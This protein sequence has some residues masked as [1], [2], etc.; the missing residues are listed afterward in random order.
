MR[1]HASVLQW[2]PLVQISAVFR[3]IWYDPSI[4]NRQTERKAKEQIGW[5]SF[6]STQGLWILNHPWICN[7]KTSKYRLA[8][9]PHSGCLTARD[10]NPAHGRKN[11]STAACQLRSPAWT[12]KQVRKLWGNGRDRQHRMRLKQQLYSWHL[13]YYSLMKLTSDQWSF[14]LWLHN[15]SF[16]IGLFLLL[17]WW[18][19]TEEGCA[20][21]VY[22]CN[23]NV[24]YP[25]GVVTY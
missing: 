25:S 12:L 3:L 10:T 1:S 13:F 11:E 17:L 8:S 2:S 22:K 5:W 16:V 19:V 15:W 6:R 21:Y 4:E 18:W 14:Q 23:C 20:R 24:I 9:V 7:A